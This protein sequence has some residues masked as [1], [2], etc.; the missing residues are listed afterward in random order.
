MSL[1][2]TPE[3]KKLRYRDKGFQLSLLP[4]VSTNGLESG[5]YFNKIS[6]NLLSGISAGNYYFELAGLSNLSTNSAGGIQIA[7]LVNMIGSNTYLN[8]TLNEEQTAKKEGFSAD[9]QGI[10]FSGALNFVRNHAK[11]F[12]FSGG[13]NVVQ[14]NAQVV[15]LAGLG[16]AVGGQHDGLQVAGLYNVATR[17]TGAQVATLYNG[18][19][20]SVTGFQVAM[21]NKSKELLG[22]NTSPPTSV[23]GFQIGAINIAR[24][25]GGT[26]IGLINIAGK[27]KGT[28]IGLINI[29]SNSPNKESGK[30]NTPIGLINLGGFSGSHIEISANELFLTS[31]EL[32][33]GNCQNCT[34]VATGMPFEG[35]FKVMNQNALIYSFN[36]IEGYNESVRWGAGYGFKKVLYNKMSM[37]ATKRARDVRKG[38]ESKFLSFGI[39][40][41]HLNREEQFQKELSLLT[42]LHADVG[43]RRASHFYLYAGFSANFYF[44]RDQNIEHRALELSSGSTDNINYQVWLGYILGIHIR[45]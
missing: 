3:H 19:N 9:F 30:G 39:Q 36:P 33:T 7:G 29:F 43:I 38:N 31:V 45:I 12:Q 34:T 26:Q 1:A 13:F 16:N 8:M 23:R 44:H 40:V 17:G 32:T 15:Q 2:Q 20:G 25:T 11:G 5:R 35:K 28:Q 24:A 27:A 18:T 10:H 14:R 42:K 41:F 4:G 6:L 22:K 37:I 21:I